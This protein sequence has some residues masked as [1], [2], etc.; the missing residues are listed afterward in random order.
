M[1]KASL[2]PGFKGLGGT[3][4]KVLNEKTG[5]ILSRRQYA[6]IKHG[7]MTNEAL[8]KINKQFHA[9]ESIARPARGRKSIQKLAPEIKKTAAQVRLEAEAQKKAKEK[10]QKL[11]KRAD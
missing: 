8:T 2:L 1:P 11:E 10:K 9:E 4:K 3:S 6:K 5:E 7:G